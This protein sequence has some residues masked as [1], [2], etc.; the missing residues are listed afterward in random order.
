MNMK[1][2]GSD[3]D[4]LTQAMIIMIYVLI[5]AASV[6]AVVVLYNLGLLS[7]TEMEREIATLKVIGLKSK[8]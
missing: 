3:W 8:S 4:K 5:A 1:Q 6:L 7:F 2:L